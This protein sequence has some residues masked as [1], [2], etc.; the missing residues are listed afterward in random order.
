MGRGPSVH[1]LWIHIYVPQK[2]PPK[3]DYVF[4]EKT[5]A[6]LKK[7]AGFAGIQGFSDKYTID[8][9]CFLYYNKG[10]IFFPVP[11]TAG[12]EIKGIEERIRL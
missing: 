5:N 6:F 3:T 11:E 1:N 10:T 8:N 4:P 12:S 7:A 2:S 9:G